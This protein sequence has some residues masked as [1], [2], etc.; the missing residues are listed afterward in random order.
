M[1]AH[2]CPSHDLLDAFAHGEPLDDPAAAHI[3]SCE[4]CQ[5]AVEEIR[6]NNSFLEIFAG[7]LPDGRS[8]GGSGSREGE[9]PPPD[10]LP[11]YRIEGEMYRGGQGIVYRATQIRTKRPVAFKMLLRGSLATTRQRLRFEREAEIVA[12][13]RHPGI[14]TVYDAGYLE[15][16]RFGFA[17][18]LIE[19]VTLDRWAGAEAV[20]NKD[21]LTTRLRLFA[22]ICDAASFAHQHGVIHRDLKPANIL[23]DAEGRPHILDFGIAKA[24][25]SDAVAPLM[26]GGAE[27]QAASAKASAHQTLPGEFAGTPAYASPE[28][29]SGDPRAIDTR[30]DVYSLGVILYQLMTGHLPY[31]VEGSLCEVVE[32]ITHESP[33]PPSAEVSIL[34]DDIDAIVLR[35]LHKDKERRYASVADLQRD[36]E[37]FLEGR[38]IETRRDSAWYVVRKTVRR[39][40]VVTSSAAAAVVVLAVFAAA[41]TLLYSQKTAAEIEARQQL[42]SRDIQHG[43]TEG[44][45]GDGALALD[46]LWRA[47]LEPGPGMPEPGPIRFGNAIEPLDS[48]WALWEF[49]SQ[50]PCEQTVG[51]A[52]DSFTTRPGAVSPDGTL[53][54][55]GGKSGV[56]L[57]AL[58]GLRVLEEFP[59]ASPVSHVVFA[60]DGG[61]I[62][63]LTESHIARWSLAE[64]ALIREHPLAIPGVGRSDCSPDGTVAFGTGAPG[65]LRI[66]RPTEPPESFDL[67]A[68][69]GRVQLVRFSADGSRLVSVSAEIANYYDSRST[70]SV[71][72]MPEGARLARTQH[73]GLING[74]LFSPD[75]KEVVLT[76]SDMEIQ[77]WA[78]QRQAEPVA[79][80]TTDHL[81][82]PQ[83]WLGEPPMLVTTESD[84]TIRIWHL[85]QGRLVGELSGHSDVLRRVEALADQSSLVSIGASSIRTWGEYAPKLWRNLNWE[86]DFA[87]NRAIIS[88]DG[89]R[90]ASTH[91][92][93]GDYR[94]ILS[95]M[96]GAGETD[97]ELVG[98]K[99]F[100]PSIAFN[101]DGSLLVSTDYQGVVCVWETS[102]GSLLERFTDHTA[103]VH[104]SAFSP[105]ADVLASGGN[106]NTVLLRNLDTGQMHILSDHTNRIPGVSFSPDGR[107]LASAS[108]DGTVRLWDVATGKAQQVFVP[109]NGIGVRT[110]RFSPIGGMLA[111]GSDDDSL[112]LIDLGS[113]EIVSLE[114]HPDD[115]FNLAFGPD[116]RVLVSGDRAGNL[117][118]WDVRTHKR[119]ITLP[120]HPD[121]IM[122]ISISPDGATMVT[123]SS[124]FAPEIRLWDLGAFAPHIAGNLEFQADRLGDILGREPTNL[125]HMLRWAYEARGLGYKGD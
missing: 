17:M 76:N 120:K 50:N 114:G 40:W 4:T 51:L 58:P 84:R 85:E 82:R 34:D 16:G 31:S 111:T 20:A 106:D 123:S 79:I 8:G 81:A 55:M 71:W 1:D 23:V 91:N 75:S 73:A 5:H 72:A 78:Y 54:A 80:V 99:D 103:R 97:I 25:E 27:A 104:S 33:K 122:S 116:G 35:A 10:V 38:P 65:R 59:S 39:H 117:M 64:G 100:V 87:S 60:A 96:D 110:V 41:M 90:L 42:R 45:S 7:V 95:D 14:V 57:R 49:Y 93:I 53:L 9:P 32:R 105:V 29:V 86:E 22:A 77:R 115:V 121:M 101:H 12:A 61:S 15:D 118:V 63:T 36:V 119:L 92:A 108:M 18:E 30:T 52:D 21:E 3:A 2:D 24:F 19:G 68:G 37:L 107:V 89:Q 112:A 43:H 113:G 66:V 6:T 13:L 94:I 67:D 83:C 70:I 125:A 48:Y 102:S 47:Q 26:F 74:L 28:Q 88:P 62:T 46:L 98:H 109:H 44:L 56:R 11:G 69:P 124:G